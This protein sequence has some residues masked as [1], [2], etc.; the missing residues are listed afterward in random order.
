MSRFIRQW[1]FDCVDVNKLKKIKLRKPVSDL[2]FCE[3]LKESLIIYEDGLSESIEFAMQNRKNRELDERSEQIVNDGYSIQDARVFVL[4]DGKIML[5]YFTIN[6]TKEDKVCDLIYYLLDKETLT[7]TGEINRIKIDRA[8]QNANLM[9]YTI[10]DGFFIP[11]L[12]TL[13]K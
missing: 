12:V 5:T 7:K 6:D 4:P 10:V 8:D 11:S 9:G 1:D 3:T 13:C 2:V